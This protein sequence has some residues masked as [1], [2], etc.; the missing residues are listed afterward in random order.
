[1]YQW[2]VNE[3]K[4]SPEILLFLSL[5]FGYLIGY[6]RFGK[7]Q[8]GGV[9]GS[10]IMGVVLSLF[11][12]EIDNGVKAVLFAVFIYAVGFESGP[13][14]FRSL[15]PKS[16]KEIFLALFVA[17]VSFFTVIIMARL[18]SLDKGLAA[19]LAAGGLT[20]SAI[21]GTAGDALSHL[22]LAPAELKKLQDNIAIGYAVTYVFGSLGAII[23]CV[24]ILPKFMGKSIRDDAICAEKQRLHGAISLNPNQELALEDIVSRVYRYS[25]RNATQVQTFEKNKNWIT[26]ERIKRNR[27][28]IDVM[29]ST[30]I[31][32]NDIL[33][34]VGRRENVVAAGD[35]IGTELG[36][37][38]GMEVVM[39]TANIVLRT[40]KY[41]NKPI[42]KI[43]TDKIRHGVYVLAIHR[44][45][46]KLTLTPDLKLKSGDIVTLYGADNDVKRVAN[47]IGD[48]IPITEKTDWVYHGFGIA[49]GLIIGLIVLRIG[50]VPLTLGAGGG[51]L[52]S[53]LLFGWFRN[54]HQLI[55]NMPTAASQILK[56]LG[57]AGFVAVI[58]LQSGYEAINTIIESGL[59]LFLIGVV[60]T[61]LPLLLAMVFGRYVLRYDNSAIFAGAL[62]GSRSANPAFGGV[63]DKAGNSIPTTPFA[64]TYALA[65]VF[66]TLL[67]PLIV[68]FG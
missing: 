21:I 17:A 10:L 55:G 20:Q 56:D 29:P 11:G 63:L 52:L 61:V 25:K 19:G 64:I 62:S 54:S 4:H 45:S 41:L 37:A 53:G 46:E 12:V 16:A 13:Q 27:Q 32:H 60:V 31:K 58:G 59:T 1:M 67:G 26:V 48:A 44:N 33:L 28:F 51:A 2:I 23:I 66:L 68:A 50:G 38:T 6:I 30:R 14:F 65:N 47:D 40:K 7:F 34:I 42:S 36:C 3:L 18:F 9:A 8:L 49:L 57:L 24:N 5:G 39:D 15:G 43:N 22:G 35:A